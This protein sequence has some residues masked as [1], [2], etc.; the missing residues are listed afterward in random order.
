[1]LTFLE[2]CVNR[3][4]CYVDL[5]CGMQRGGG[6]EVNVHGIVSPK[7]VVTLIFVVAYRGGGG[8]LTF[9]ALCHQ[10]MLLL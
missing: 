7:D 9:M 2:Y 3:R 1:M 8:M 6:G 10:K 5:R 4:C